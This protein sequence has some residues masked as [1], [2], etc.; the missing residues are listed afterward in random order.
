G[1]SSDTLYKELWHACAR[2]LITVPRQG[3]RIYHFPHVYM[4]QDARAPSLPKH[5]KG[6]HCKKSGRLKKYCE[7]FQA[8]ILC[9]KNCK[10][11]DCKN[12]EGSEEL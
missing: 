8:N 9:S 2:P 11:M 1:S 12:F 4:E 10:C 5:N 6:W 3:E 7:C